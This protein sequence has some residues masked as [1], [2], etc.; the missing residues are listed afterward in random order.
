MKAE[1]QHHI[2]KYSYVLQ[3]YLSL[4]LRLDF[5]IGFTFCKRV[6]L[7]GEIHCIYKTKASEL[8]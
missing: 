4:V 7:T 6:L 5:K 1:I 3:P 8:N 2:N